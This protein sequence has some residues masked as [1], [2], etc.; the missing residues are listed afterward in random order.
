MNETLLRRM[1]SIFTDVH[2]GRAIT[3][4]ECDADIRWSEENAEIINQVREAFASDPTFEALSFEE[5]I[6][7]VTR[8]YCALSKLPKNEN[9][10]SQQ[11]T[12]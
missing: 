9:Q 12:M 4:E 3:E 10:T 6:A 8:L 1:A 7:S 2:F 5:Q 11:K